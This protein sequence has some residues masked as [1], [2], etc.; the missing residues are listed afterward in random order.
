MDKQNSQIT[1]TFDSNVWESIVD[2]GKRVN[3]P[4]YEAIFTTITSG[5]IRPFFFEGVATIETVPK[6][7]RIDHFPNSRPRI[8]VKISDN[9]TRVIEG[10][11]APKLSDYLSVNLPLALDL[12]FKFIRLPRIGLPIVPEEFWANDEF[13]TLEDRLERS[14]NF[15]QHIESLGMGRAKLDRETR[16][17][18]KQ[19]TMGTRLVDKTRLRKAYAKAVAEWADGDA[20]AAHYGYGIDYFCTNDRG[21]SAGTDSVFF[22]SKLNELR[23]R[24]SLKIVDPNELI[25]VMHNTKR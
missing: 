3:N 11:P 23:Q 17:I 22:A 4:A 12:G 18:L 13:F 16:D 14:F 2:P 10:T 7:N 24:F 21:R 19:Q 6:A 8:T 15:S 5:K 9:P 25:V 1:V 20:L